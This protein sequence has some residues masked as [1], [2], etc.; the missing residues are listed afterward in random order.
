MRMLEKR[1]TYALTWSES[2]LIRIRHDLEIFLRGKVHILPPLRRGGP[3]ID[4]WLGWGRKASGAHAIK[5]AERDG[6]GFLLLEDGF[7]RSHGL[8]VNGARALSIVA[9]ATG[10]YYDATAPSDLENILNTGSF[11]QEEI[12]RAKELIIFL[13]QEELSKYNIGLP[14][15][16]NPFP[17]DVERVLIVDQTANDASLRFGLADEKTFPAMLEAALAENP[18]AE[19]FIRTHPDVLAG[20]REGALPRIQHKR[21]S[22]LTDNTHPQ[23]L[24]RYFDKV[25]VATSLMGMDALIRGKTV[26]CFGMPFYAGWGLTQ[27]ELVCPRRSAR[28]SLEEL[29]AAAYLRYARYLNP[30]TDELCDAITVAR[31]LAK[32]RQRV[33]QWAKLSGKPWK[34]RVIAFGFNRWKRAQAR[35]FFGDG[36]QVRFVRTVGQARRLG[37]SPHDRLAVWGL[38]DASGLSGL[39]DELGTPLVRVEDGFIRSVG[40]GSDF[41]PPVSLVFDARGIYFNPEQESD[42]E[43]ILNTCQFSNEILE[44]AEEL[45][46]F[47]IKYDLTKYNALVREGAE[48]SC[49]PPTDRQV[50][51]VPGQV[52]DDASIIKGCVE[53]RTNLALLK[54]ARAE[55]P[56]AFIIYKPHPDV[57]SGNRRGKLHL[58]AARNFCDHVETKADILTCIRHVNSVHTMTSLAGFDALLRGKKVICHGLPF[59][60]GWGLTEDRLPIPRRSRKLS[61]PELVAGTL[62]IYPV[63]VYGNEITSIKPALR[64]LLRAK[65]NGR[66][67]RWRIARW[68]FWTLKSF[69]QT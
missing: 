19:I 44:E 48:L 14:I 47:I 55:N 61:M 36:V 56:D 12:A 10:I 42:L 3:E 59:Y 40:L 16:E 13:R 43:H 2:G 67:R 57:L 1:A 58:D 33:R 41:I 21:I 18:H 62:L 50:I 4:A 53:V 27:D 30:E 15:L 20:K 26:R 46:D 35:P 23:D 64:H 66:Y 29:V 54:Q 68:I 63:Y 5:L 6:T 24:L 22:W 7:L 8:G 39:V 69:K 38:K 28:R 37:V 52:E 49:S 34:G 60:A 65:E 51:L 17:A 11:S 9:D 32:Q 31:H 25:Y 45:T